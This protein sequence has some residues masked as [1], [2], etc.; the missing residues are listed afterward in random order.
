MGEREA[1]G[2]RPRWIDCGS[3]G[4]SKRWSTTTGT[5]CTRLSFAASTEGGAV[6][7]AVHAH[8]G[9]GASRG[10]ADGF[11]TNPSDPSRS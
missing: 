1:G 11:A 4:Y 10:A 5:R 7:D 6:R 8:S 3:T 2:D 9:C